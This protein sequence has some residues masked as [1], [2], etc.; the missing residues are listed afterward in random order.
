MP[1]PDKQ[2]DPANPENKAIT[3]GMERDGDFLRDVREGKTPTE[4]FTGVDLG[5][6]EFQAMQEEHQA[7]IDEVGEVIAEEAETQRP[8]AVDDTPIE[9]DTPVLAEDSQPSPVQQIADEH[10]DLMA[11][12]GRV[13]GKE[14]VASRAAQRASDRKSR[15]QAEHGQRF[16]ELNETVAKAEP[17]DPDADAPLTPD[18]MARVKH[19]GR[20]KPG[21]FGEA[22]AEFAHEDKAYRAA[23][24]DLLRLMAA[25][26]RQARWE[27]DSIRG[28]IERSRL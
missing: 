26:M 18:A 24:T 22:F 27:L 10:A 6:D 15:L 7:L 23:L 5:T 17:N 25:E 2:F 28:Y 19:P 1:K 20:E 21:E 14:T 11:E 9:V 16:A 12:V 4:Q 3:D 8:P 13:I